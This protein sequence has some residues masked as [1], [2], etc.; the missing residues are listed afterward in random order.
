MEETIKLE[1]TQAEAALLCVVLDQLNQ[2]LDESNAHSEKVH[3]EIDRLQA[4]N[5]VKLN[6]LETML[7][8]GYANFGKRTS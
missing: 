3:A 6:Q 7:N 1:I 8:A 4:E 5:G 2:V